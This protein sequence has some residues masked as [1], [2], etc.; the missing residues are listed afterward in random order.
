MIRG[1]HETIPVGFMALVE[2]MAQL[3]GL[4]EK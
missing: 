3:S 4:V 1:Q 2:L